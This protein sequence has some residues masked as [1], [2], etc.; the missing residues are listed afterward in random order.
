MKKFFH[1][2]LILKSRRTKKEITFSIDSMHLLFKITFSFNFIYRVVASAIFLAGIVS[3]VCRNQWLIYI[4]CWFI[5]RRINNIHKRSNLTH[6]FRIVCM[7]KSETTLSWKISVLYIIHIDICIIGYKIISPVIYSFHEYSLY[8]L[9]FQEHD[10]SNNSQLNIINEMI[11]LYHCV[12]LANWV[13]SLCNDERYY[14]HV[15]RR[16]NF[17]S[18]S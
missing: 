15:Y 4:F 5:V 11:N 3:G 6:I 18:N 2:F 7:I 12:W 13:S 10:N 14:N 9:I 16:K 1:F 17:F 8:R